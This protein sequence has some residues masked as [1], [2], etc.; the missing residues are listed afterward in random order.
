MEFTSYGF[1]VKDLKTKHN[2]LSSSNQDGLYPLRNSIN[3]PNAFGLTAVRVTGSTWHRRLGHANSR[4]L[5]H[6][7]QCS[8]IACNKSENSDT[9]LCHA[10]QLGKHVRLPFDQS[11]SHTSSPFE[12]IHSDIWVSPVSSHS[13]YHYFLTFLDDFSYYSWVYPLKHKH[14]V[15]THFLQFHVLIKNQFHATIKMFQCDNGTEYSNS[16]FWDFFRTNG[17]HFSFFL[18]IHFTT[19]WES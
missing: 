18:S 6:L 5:F 2:I 19:K 4:V 12:L 15:F 7:F 1:C 9:C 11:K 10:C 14:E 13:S 3:P 17:I 16:S 8:L